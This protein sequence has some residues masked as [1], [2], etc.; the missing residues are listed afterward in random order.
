MKN[1]I[2]IGKTVLLAAFLVAFGSCKDTAWNDHYSFKE[3]ESKYP[4]EKLAETL[5]L[6]NKEGYGKFYDA[7][8]YTKMVDKHGRAINITYLELLEEDQF[9]TVWAPSDA[10]NVNWDLYTKKNK[11][12]AEHKQVG[13]EFIMNHIARFK[14]SVGAGK[15]E[16]VYMLNGKPYY[17]AADD[18]A[19]QTYHA[20]DKNIRCSNG[21][22]HFL[23][24]YLS[25]R[26]NIYEFLTTD[27]RYKDIIGDWFKSYTIEELDPTRS[28]AQG[29]NE[30]G[31][32][33]YVDSVMTE[34][35]ILLSNFGYINSE[36]STFAL[37]L[38]TPEVWNSNYDRI[39]EYFEY[40][41]ENLNNDSLQKFYTYVTMFGDLIFNTNPIVQKFLPDSIFSTQYYA[42]EN[43]RDGKPYHI[44]AKPYDKVN[45]LFGSC[46]DSVE[47]SNGTV[48]IID[49]WPFADELSFRRPIIM[50]AENASGGNLSRFVTTFQTIRAIDDTIMLPEPIQVMRLS[51]EGMSKWDAQ[52]YISNNLKGKYT[53]KA[54]VVPNM[55]SRDNS[56]PGKKNHLPNSLHP[57][58]A[59]D[60]P[61]KFDSTLVDSI[62]VIITYDSKGRPRRTQSEYIIN[63]KIDNVDTLLLGTINIPY[64]N[65]AMNQR[66]LSVTLSSRV[67]N[68]S[69]YTSE[70]W[71][72]CFILEPV[73]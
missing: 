62:A 12:D 20:D 25:I 16:K 70:L 65:Y 54:V 66:R 61:T 24:G 17:S 72:D 32:M 44:F 33:V 69:K 23:N 47:C 9:M 5:S 34:Y 59:Y 71:L 31:E 37:V 7:L 55:N 64:C 36:D 51:M 43:R 21:I 11:T 39:K 40:K 1:Y 35:S 28:V 53:V 18:I 19:G 67:D 30:N 29:I 41:E 38:P 8:R 13:E 3:T 73:E 46:I 45:G 6:K 27:P 14:H 68:V 63:N 2:S 26:P 60:T 15:E 42:Y 49:K 52:F 57:R 22:L 58:I 56:S 4:V 48:Y 50:E 10:A